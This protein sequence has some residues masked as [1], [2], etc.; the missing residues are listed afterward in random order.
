VVVGDQL[1]RLRAAWLLAT[2]AGLMAASPIA[3]LV[4][5]AGRLDAVTPELVL[6]NRWP[7]WLAAAAL[8]ALAAGVARDIGRRPA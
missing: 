2:A 4:G 3:Y 7:H 8:A 6:G 5:N 1:I